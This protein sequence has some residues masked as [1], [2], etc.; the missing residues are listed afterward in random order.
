MTSLTSFFVP[1]VVFN[2]QHVKTRGFHWDGVQIPGDLVAAP[3]LKIQVSGFQF[4]SV[5]GLESQ[6]LSQ[7]QRW[8]WKPPWL[9][10]CFFVGGIGC[11]WHHPLMRIFYKNS[12]LGM[13]Y[14]SFGGSLITKCCLRGD[15]WCHGD[16]S[17]GPSSSLSRSGCLC[18]GFFF[19][20]T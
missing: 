8:L 13:V 9:L 6:K 5:V 15:G 20:S 18:I 19:L 17:M 14:I 2:V 1:W 10:C 3:N 11:I 7:V 12:I 16:P 4:L